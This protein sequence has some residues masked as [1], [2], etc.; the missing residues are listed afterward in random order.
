MKKIMTRIAESEYILIVL[1]GLVLLV[2]W[3]LKLPFAA[4]ISHNFWMFFVE[5][6]TFLPLMFILIGLIDVW[7]P[8]EK[9]EK[10]IGQ[11]AGVKGTVWVILLA[12]LQ[13][14]PLYGAFPV[15]HLL[16]KK[17]CSIRN[18]FIY[19]GAFATLKLP[20]MTFEVGF[21]GLKFSLLRTLFTLPV[22]I[23]IAMFMEFHLQ[24]K[25]FEVRQ[26]REGG[27]NV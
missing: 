14:G 25:G 26:T 12:M 5:M 9:V 23:L 15:A 11:E 6:V 22:F 2:S 20:M 17:G 18:I 21:L 1:A 10:H 3:L 8:R 13:A 27:K 16:W 24:D 7:F 4:V 19:L